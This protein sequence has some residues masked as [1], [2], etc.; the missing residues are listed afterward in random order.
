MSRA[1]VL[2]KAPRRRR[3]PAK[4]RRRARRSGGLNSFARQNRTDHS[5]LQESYVVDTMNT[6]TIYNLNTALSTYTRASH[7]AQMYQEYKITKVTILIKP[8]LDTYNTGGVVV[9]QLY[10]LPVRDGSTVFTYT[11]FFKNGVKPTTFAKDAN[12]S[13]SYRPS[14]IYAGE[15]DA[16]RNTIVKTSPWLNTDFTVGAGSFSPNPTLHYGASWIALAAPFATGAVNIAS[17]EVRV[18]FK[19]R[20]PAYQTISAHND[21]IT[22]P[23]VNV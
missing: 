4:G 15:G 8:N 7:V 12:H 23:I 22:M 14:I 11:D 6:Q 16:G 2:R 5:S 9:P 3:A 18:N 17:F 19:F 20:K 21:A 1:L 13:F 10:F